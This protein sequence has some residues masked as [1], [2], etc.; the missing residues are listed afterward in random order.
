MVLTALCLLFNYFGFRS[1]TIMLTTID[2]F[3]DLPLAYD[4]LFVGTRDS[5]P[6]VIARTRF[7]VKFCPYPDD[8]SNKKYPCTAYG[9]VYVYVLVFRL[10]DCAVRFSP[11]MSTPPRPI[12]KSI[13]TS[14]SA[15]DED[16]LNPFSWHLGD[17]FVTDDRNSRSRVFSKPLD[18]YA[19]DNDDTLYS[20]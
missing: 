9:T 16:K 14:R 17:R 6:I 2:E 13:S 18:A 11:T 3:H 15:D 19:D 20:S 4:I 5:F 7:A 8:V 1:R 10:S 12:L